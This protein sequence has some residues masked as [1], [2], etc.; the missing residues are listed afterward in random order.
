MKDKKI[1]TNYIFNTSYQLLALI[2][3][4]VTTPYIS[5]VLKA[6]GIGLYS[7]TY[8]IVSYFTLCAILGTATYGNK[9]IGILQ[10]NPLERTK[11]FW[12]IFLLRFITSAIALLIY[13][14]YV[15][16]F[17]DNKLISVIQSFYILGVMFDVS[18]FFQGM[19]DFK[20]I[21]IRNYIFKVINVIAIFLFIHQ[22]TDLW[23]YVFSLALL[24]WIGNLSIWP[25]LRKYLVRA[26]HYRPKPFAGFRTIY[27]LFIPAAAIQ[28]Y[29]MLDKTMIGQ[30]TSDSAQNGYY[31]QSE[32]IVKMCLMLVTALPTVLLPKVS[33][34]Y[35][36]KRTDDAKSYLYKS[37]NFVWFLGTPLM[38]GVAGIAPILV[39]VFFGKGYEPVEYILQIMS[40]LFIIMGLN[41]TTGTQFFIAC[42]QQNVYTRKIVIGGAI[43]VCLN[44][45]LIPFLGAMGAAIASVVGEIIIM[46]TELYY[47]ER[48]KH[49][50]VIKIFELCKKYTVA[51]SIMF[52]ILRVVLVWAVPTVTNLV[53]LI[54][55]G[56]LIYLVILLIEKEAFA[57]SGLEIIHKLIRGLERKLDKNC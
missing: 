23:K 31:E 4:L 56:A 57:R 2:V 24:T 43:N 36:E 47:I 21:A 8:S 1:I 51:G 17:A 25:Y 30:I 55:M 5:R 15:C 50:S 45:I 9:Q 32:K 48:N 35:A 41:Q 54:V 46:M 12:D 28:I 10:D 42:G 38:F 52:V 33:K 27:Q 37:Y 39:P 19:E 16:L 14:V 11:K 22:G 40:L 49:Y 26:S 44:V 29:A 34:A 7:Y 13:L 18:W 3:P 6:E 20:R 53:M